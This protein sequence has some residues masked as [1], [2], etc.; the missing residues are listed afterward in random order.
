MLTA[1]PAPEQAPATDRCR[2]R[3]GGDRGDCLGV[4]CAVP[5]RAA[6]PQGGGEGML[7]T[8]RGAALRSALCCAVLGSSGG[9]ALAGTVAA[10]SGAC[11]CA[12]PR[13][14]SRLCT[15][16]SCLPVLQVQPVG[17]W[18]DLE[19]LAGQ[20]WPRGAL[21]LAASINIILCAFM[22]QHV[23]GQGALP[24]AASMCWAGAA[25]EAGSML[26]QP[27]A[28]RGGPQQACHSMASQ[29]MHH[30]HCLQAFLPVVRELE[31][32]AP[33]RRMARAAGGWGGGM[34]GARTA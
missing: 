13:V 11:A 22:C 25:Q 28:R 6:R 1:L 12:Q 18:P 5:R 15:H 34:A 24:A 19:L 7:G 8:R 16:P 32:P 20:P 29:G 10:G 17:L 9:P 30:T 23:G 14:T 4:R 31:L 27:Y 3:P 26:E 33:P 2:Q 21:Q